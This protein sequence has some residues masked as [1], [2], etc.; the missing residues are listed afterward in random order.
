MQQK[1]NK[2]IFLSVFSVIAAIVFSCIRILLMIKGFDFESLF[3]KNDLPATLLYCFVL[4]G[5]LLIY[6]VSK[7]NI[8]LTQEK[9]VVSTLKDILS[10]IVFV[11]LFIYGLKQNI[12]TSGIAQITHYIS[13]V[14]SLIS[15]F[16]YVYSAFSNRETNFL[17]VLNIAPVLYLISELV[18]T[19]T[20]ISSR[21][22]SYYL[23]PDVISILVLAYFI[24]HES[25]AKFVTENQSTALLSI[26][27]ISVMILAFSALPDVILVST[28]R[29]SFSMLYILL[30]VLKLIYLF[31]AVYT[32]FNLTK[33]SKEELK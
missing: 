19:F 9:S 18:T 12:Y 30:T 5:S 16:F 10:M 32:V 23:F 17:R 7:N 8:T 28:H 6:I 11:L 3:Y 20:V 27:L 33:T 2:L 29:I 31:F 13:L 22:N 25:K 15:V 26:S 14:T 24:L 21:A 4:I 1:S